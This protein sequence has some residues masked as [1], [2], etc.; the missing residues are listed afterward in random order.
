MSDNKNTLPARADYEIGYGKPPVHTRFA[1]GRS[2][3]PRGRPKGAKNQPNLPA[4]NEE[5]LK[6]IIIEEAYRTIRVNEA[7]GIV[8]MTIAQAVVRSLAVNAAKGNQRAQRLFT[9]L[10]AATERDRKRLHDEWMDTAMEYKIE[11]ERELERR[12]RFGI[13]GLPEPLP[14]PDH[15]VIDIRKGT[16]EIRGPATKEEKAKWDIWTE[17]KRMFEEE[18]ADLEAN[19]KD[20][21]CSH[22]DI[23]L[24]E[25]E[26]TK[27]VLAIIN[28]ALGQHE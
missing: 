2:G 15:V 23:I 1:P 7:A 25:I 27:K 10:L 21:E 14:H 20:P 6:D 8:D 5:R 24:R 22:R 9:D 12:H 17:R 3:N 4:L 13:L 28:R 18:L 26:S 19:L 16:A 11:W